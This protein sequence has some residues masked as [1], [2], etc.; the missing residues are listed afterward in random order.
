MLDSFHYPRLIDDQPVRGNARD[1]KKV[2]GFLAIAR[3]NDNNEVP[4]H[5]QPS[6]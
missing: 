3:R 2:Q 5:L 6:T 4:H 1:K